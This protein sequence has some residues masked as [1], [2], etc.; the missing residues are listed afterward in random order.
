MPTLHA[1]LRPQ[2]HD[3]RRSVDVVRIV[4]A[5]ILV[6]HPIYTLT[7]AAA[8][9]ALVDGL[10]ARGLPAPTVFAWLA[11]LSLLVAAPALLVR[12]L[13]APAAVTA[14]VIL[15]SGAALLYAPRWYV[16]G[17]ASVEGHPGIEFNV[18]LVACLAG[19]AWTSWPRPTGSEANA[20]EIGLDIIRLA[21]ALLDLAASTARLPD[22]G[23]RRHASLRRGHERGRLS[24]RRAFGL[25]HD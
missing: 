17:G 9:V 3:C 6:V 7:H 23:C 4:I 21:G 10:R 15:I 11:N 13:V 24:L 12:R 1:W 22:V 2:P 5:A 8:M 18:L 19:V 25:V 16:A 14:I 20:A